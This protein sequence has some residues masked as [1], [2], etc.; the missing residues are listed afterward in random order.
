MRDFNAVIG[1]VN[2]LI[3]SDWT[4]YVLLLTGVV[5]TVWSRFSQL[6][7]DARYRAAPRPL[8]R[9]HRTRRAASLPNPF[10]SAVRHR[11]PWDIGGVAIAVALGGPGACFG[12][13]VLVS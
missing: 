4:L 3:W 1:V 10:R 8:R 7:A 13:L 12:L 11:G 2:D 9:P 6:R 5:F